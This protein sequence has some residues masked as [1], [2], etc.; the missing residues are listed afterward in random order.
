MPDFENLKKALLCDGEP[1]YVPLFEGTIAQ[2]IKSQFL[3]REVDGLEDEVEFCMSAG[4]DFVP[5]TIGLRQTLRGETTGIMGTK[6]VDTSVLA[7]AEAHYNPFQEEKNTRMWAEHG[8]GVIHDEASYESF[9]WPDPDKFSYDTVELLG[10]LLPDNAKAIINVGYIFTAPWML[11]GLEPFC[12]SL[13]LGEELPKRLINRVGTIQ[14]RVVENLVQFDCVGAIR[15]PDD[16]AYTTG[17]IISPRLLREY[18]FPWNTVIGKVAQD[19]GLLYLL[20]S[21]GLLY[22]VMDDMVE[23]GFRAVH[24]CEPSSMDIIELKKTYG[25]KLCV[26]GNIDLDSTL[27]LGTPE[28]VEEEVKER[29]RTLA[30]GGGYCCGASNSVPEYVPYDNYIAMIDTVKKHGKYPIQL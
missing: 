18:I 30:P 13:A 25:G 3:G 28:E 24:P 8:S 15:M 7:P 20:H 1:D 14:K 23:S 12:I 4:Y 11:M 6:T 9:A 16:L 29:I 2:S 5:L 22:D 19:A 10:K 26:C 17:L 21:D 27:T